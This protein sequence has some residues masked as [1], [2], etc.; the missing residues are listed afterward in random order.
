MRLWPRS[1][2]ARVCL[3]AA[4]FLLIYLVSYIPLS[5]AGGYYWSQTGDRRW[6]YGL[7]V[8]DI[9]VWEPAWCRYQWCFL[10]IKRERVSRGNS[11]GYFYSPLILLDRA[12]FHPTTRIMDKD[13]HSLLEDTGVEPSDGSDA[14]APSEGDAS[15]T[16]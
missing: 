4:A 13:G 5:L 15:E 6:N 8:S 12:L 10:N 7:A 2:V 1:K 3:C 16:E 11:L 9:I 14:A